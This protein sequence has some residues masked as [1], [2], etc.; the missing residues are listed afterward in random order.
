MSTIN[1]EDE[2]SD[3][4]ASK[5]LPESPGIKRNRG[6]MKAARKDLSEE[7]LSTPAARQFLLDELERLDGEISELQEFRGSYYEASTKVK[8]LEER[9]L[10]S[11]E[12]EIMSNLCL[13]VGSAML[14]ASPSLITATGT[15]EDILRHY[16]WVLFTLAALLVVVSAFVKLGWFPR[17]RV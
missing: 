9:Q 1:P 17:L 4:A 15:N 6:F 14:G 12:T 13:T 2:P 7:D 11:S 5:P 10:R 16:G 3:E 8:V